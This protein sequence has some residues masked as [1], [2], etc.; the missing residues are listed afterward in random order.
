MSMDFSKPIFALLTDIHLNFLAL[1]ERR[2]FYKEI[3]A[4]S[5]THVLITGDIAEATSLEM[6]LTEINEYI[7]KKIFFVLGNHDYYDGEIAEVKNLICKISTLNVNYTTVGLPDA[8]WLFGSDSWADG[9]YGDYI[10]SDVIMNDSQLIYD[11]HISY[12]IGKRELL[13]K[14]QE[15]ADR[16]ANQLKEKLWNNIQNT[17]S[18]RDHDLFIVLT[19]IPPFPEVCKYNGRYTKKEW[20]PFFSCKATGDVLLEFAKENPGIN[21]LVLCGH[22]H[23]AAQYQALPNLLVKCGG[24]EY[25]KPKIQKIFN[26]NNLRFDKK[27]EHK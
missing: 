11:L 20:L 9:R 5:A 6:I 16:D 1:S 17:H 15:L 19:H 7:N 12:K 14:M 26:K 21:I 8:I 27:N 25:Y 4:C 22:T 10:N 24:S 13:N 3:N 18:E 23:S 2:K